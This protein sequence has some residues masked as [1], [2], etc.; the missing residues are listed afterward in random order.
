MSLTQVTGPYPIFTDLDGSP[1]DDGYLYIGDQN[2]DPE[3]NP[4][5]VFW[6]SALTIPATQ[7]IRTN[8]GYAWRN[9]T[10]GLLYTAGPFS[11]TIRNKRDEFV[12]YSPLGYG[13]DPAAVSASVVKN[14]FVGDGVEVDFTLS[15]A[16]STI[17]ATNA[18]I[19]GVYQEKDSYTLSGNV[20][21]FSIAPPLSS[22]IEILTNETGI[23]NSGNATA[24]SYT[25]TAAGAVAQTVQTKL[26]QSISVKDFGAVG[27]GVADDTTAI[28]SALTATANGS[29]HFPE[30]NYLV[31]AA[32]TAGSVNIICDGIVT[33]TYTGV[34]HINRVL[35]MNLAGAPASIS[36]KLIVNGSNKA[37]IGVFIINDNATRVALSL[38]DIEGRNCRMVS[39]SAFNAGSAGV[40][41]R[42]NF[43]TVLFDRLWAKDIGRAAGTGSVG[44]YG[45]NGVIIDRDG[46]GRAALIVN[47]AVAGAENITCDDSPGSAGAVDVDSVAVFQNDESGAA[48]QIG[49]ISSV[50]AEGRGFK[51]Q[52]YR[53]TH[54]NEISIVRSVSGTTGGNADVNLQFAEGVIDS[55]EIVYS[56]NADT[57][58][59]QGTTCVSYYTDTSR[60]N[61][62][63]VNPIRNLTVR[64]TCTTGT[65]TI[66]YITELTFAVANTTDKFAAVENVIMLGRPAKALCY[67]GPNGAT[68][69]GR[70]VL[71]IDGFVGELTNGLIANLAACPNLFAGV[72]RVWNTGSVVPAIYRTDAV[73]L[74]NIFGRI[75][76]NGGNIGILRY[77]GTGGLPG[78]VDDGV[79]GFTSS[80]IAAGLSPLISGDFAQNVTTQ[81]DKFGVSPGRGLLIMGSP[82]YGPPGIYTTT[83]NTITTVQAASGLTVGSGGTDPGG[84]DFNAWKT[85]SGTRLSIKNANATTRPFFVLVIG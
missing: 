41:V 37:N 17:L 54:I 24:I 7:P 21:T 48:C 35:D 83:G 39:G 58:H 77:R 60:A 47:G 32:L 25:L 50:D 8:S 57:V 9:G 45:T 51:A 10:P 70:F 3:T 76:D 26:E 5:Q 27:N 79:N 67:I 44:N 23:I 68:G 62:Y 13:F 2:D 65:A 74:G 81:T 20:I 22:S 34:P 16:P 15:S 30:G 28:Q 11:I 73:A 31:T 42:G 53:S 80:S 18:F 64:D 61:G 46:S 52:T 29:L 6:D 19:N 69:Y 75:I 82:D 55:C 49:F 4:I 71:K 33:I 36:G 38:G 78:I 66:N 40:V 56:G 63:G 12:L 84:A 72:S 85:D 43:T 59:G 1:L 14:D